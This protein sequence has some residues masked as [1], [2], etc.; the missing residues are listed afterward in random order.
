MRVPD[1]DSGAGDVAL[2]ATEL[3][4]LQVRVVGA[5]TNAALLETARAHP[6]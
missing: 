1:V 4:G 5:D 2:L 3:V 6:R